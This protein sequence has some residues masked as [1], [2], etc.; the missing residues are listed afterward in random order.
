MKKLIFSL[1][2]ACATL[3]AAAQQLVVINGQPIP[4]DD[5]EWI[6]YRVDVDFKCLPEVLAED[7]T[8]T[9]FSQAL[10][11][12]GLADSLMSYYD[13][14]Y[15]YYAYMYKDRSYYVDTH[16]QY[17]E[18]L[19]RR[20]LKF[21]AFVETD[22]V[23]A[24]H[25]ITTLDGLKAYAKRVYDE[26]YPED[27]AVTDPTDRRHSLNRFV[28]YHLLPF[29][30]TRETLTAQP[31]YFRQDIADV[32]DW[33]QTLMPYGSL[34]VS[35]PR[36]DN[37][38]N[39]EIGLFL[40][41]RGLQNGSDKYGV[42]TRGVEIGESVETVNGYYYYIDDLLAYDKKTQSETLQERWRV[43]FVT[44]SPDFMTAGTRSNVAWSYISTESSSMPAIGFESTY[45]EGMDWLHEDVFIA[46]SRFYFWNY[47]G[48]EVDVS[49][50]SGVFDVT[51]E[52][53]ALPEGEWE[54]RFG[55]CLL[56]DNP[57]VRFTLDDDL[58]GTTV[59]LTFAGAQAGGSD[60]YPFE[61]YGFA[62]LGWSS[63]NGAYFSDPE[64]A[65]WLQQNR[66]R[67][68]ELLLTL[69]L[70]VRYPADITYNASKGCYERKSQWATYQISDEEMEWINN[71][72]ATYYRSLAELP[73]LIYEK[74][75]VAVD[76]DHV[77]DIFTGTIYSYEETLPDYT[78]AFTRELF[79]LN[80]WL[81]GPTD[82]V[83]AMSNSLSQ[84][85]WQQNKM[86][87][88]YQV[89][90]LCRSIVGRFHT[91]GK[92][93]HRLHIQSVYGS[94]GYLSLDYLEFCP[95]SIA[96]HPTIHEDY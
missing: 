45:T 3:T 19:R 88:M 96:D 71:N 2:V 6:S 33:Y 86:T 81:Y 27:A 23:L 78:Q 48:D 37:N 42:Q 34:K 8:A 63:N 18:W 41:R 16:Y 31:H 51:V 54:L 56:P 30:A 39:T 82:Y 58:L 89:M 79:R 44:L 50:E 29:G 12:T 38:P 17:V 70:H 67:I 77:K 91:D 43:D 13:F 65:Q 1:A 53:P 94:A 9:L 4:A 62:D 14:D 32:A 83:I 11:L 20:Y 49:C 28:A 90:N 47:G 7:E 93:R 59:N 40:N 72:A 74:V 73:K 15:D 92:S 84:D 26:V 66:S 36:T 46:P 80:G 60:V 25:G 85:G 57:T 68:D 75:F 24:A 76:D 10:Q 35:R 95:V 52:L 22:A 61:K 87:S 5:I 55:G 21:T 69:P 64:H